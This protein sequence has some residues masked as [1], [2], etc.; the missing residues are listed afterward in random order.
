MLKEIIADKKREVEQHKKS[1]PLSLLEKRIALCKPV[2]DF[3]AAFRGSGLKLIA[4]VKQASPSR[5]ILVADYNPV[6][7]AEAYSEGGAAAISVLTEEKYFKGSLEHLSAIRAKVDLPLLR[8]DFIFDPYQIYEAR[9]YGADSLLLIAAILS[10][11]QLK[12]LLSLSHLLGLKCLVEIHQESEIEKVLINN[13]VEVIGINNRDLSTFNVDIDTTR[14][15]RPLIPEDIIVVSESGIKKRNDID[16]LREW[17]INA[18][19]IGET[20]VTAGDISAK[21]KELML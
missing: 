17:R 16:K 15:L 21:I 20:L 7:L 1:I 9:A 10:S 14:R 8:K 18:V 11:S 13:S 3:S 12:E 19:L 4:E 5:G 6:R 2:L